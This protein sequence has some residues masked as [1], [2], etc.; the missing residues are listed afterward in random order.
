L[1][2][3]LQ[4]LL[5]T[6]A[7][8][9]CHE[10]R[11][12]IA[13]LQTEN[14][15]LRE[16]LGKRPLRFSDAQR[17]RLATAAK[18]LPRKALIALGTL[19]TP[20]TLL[21]WYRRLVAEKYDGSDKRGP[22]RPRQRD[23]LAALIVRIARENPSW[24]YTR[25]RGALSNLGHQLARSTIARVLADHGIDP[26]PERGKAMP[27]RTFL[28]VHWGAIAAADFFTVEVLTTVGLVRYCVLFVMDLKTR[29]VHIAGIGHDPHD[30]WMAQLA[31][32]LT[33][34][35]DG[36]LKECRHLI[37][38]RDP[39]FRHA[40][41][42]ILRGAGVELVVLPARSEPQRLRRALRALHQ[43]RVPRQGHPPRRA[44]PP[45]GHRRVRRPLPHR[46]QPPRTR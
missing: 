14:R 15:V 11:D 23:E 34:P 16:L 7:G 32:N 31:R 38:D 17:R 46:T 21:R 19:V 41:A 39:L 13:Y 29:A 26:A 36:F 45:R 40:F 22:G 28:D 25:I 2:L 44:P 30:K 10:Q 35:V 18:N 37:V 20:D 5:L 4:F 12:V 24:G 33:D 42:G 43:V 9:L 3:P 8:W 1:P 27:W 6:V